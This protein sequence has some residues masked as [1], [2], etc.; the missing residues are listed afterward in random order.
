MEFR[1]GNVT[2]SYSANS[3]PG[4]KDLSSWRTIRNYV[5]WIQT[6]NPNVIVEWK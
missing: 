4:S 2:D 5:N 1:S 6:N 3:N